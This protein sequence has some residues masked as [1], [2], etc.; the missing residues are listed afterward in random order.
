MSNLAENLADLGRKSKIWFQHFVYTLTV[1]TKN[2][3]PP[4][5]FR[6]KI[7]NFCVLR[8]YTN[9]QTTMKSDNSGYLSRVGWRSKIIRGRNSNKNHNFIMHQATSYTSKSVKHATTEQILTTIHNTCNSWYNK[10]QLQNTANVKTSYTSKSVKHRDLRSFKIRFKFKSAVRFDL[11]RKGLVD[12]KIFESNR[13]CL[14]LCLVSL[15]KR[16]KPL[17]ALS[18]TVYRLASSMSDH[19]PVFNVFEDCNGEYAVLYIVF[20]FICNYRF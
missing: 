10:T 9:T 14:L 16:L 20:C 4:Y 6:V 3:K 7:S 12:S 5:S 2:Q 19:T 15:I 13:P 11:I 1:Y 8:T 18:G 17:T